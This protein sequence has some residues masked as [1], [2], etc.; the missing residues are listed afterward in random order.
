VNVK[1]KRLNEYAV[2]PQYAKSGDSGFDL[3]ATEDVIVRPGE[4][5][6]VP[7]G[8][9]FE[10]PAGYEMQVRQ[11][12]G[13]TSKTKLRVQLGTVDAGYRGEVAVMVDNIAP[14]AGSWL[15]S[16]WVTVEG[17]QYIIPADERS[18]PSG[19][20]IIRRGDRIAQGVIAPVIRATIEEADEL[21]D[22]ER[23]TSGFGDSGYR[24]LGEAEVSA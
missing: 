15:T 11:R 9:A 13:V 21:G 7:T 6:R 17:Q 19:T 22:T 20:Y 5:V 16:V 23:G 10:I 24:A 1:I 18:S 3:V 8:L 12:S 14:L 4:T 2:I